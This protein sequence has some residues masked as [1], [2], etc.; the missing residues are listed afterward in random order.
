MT[1]AQMQAIGQKLLTQLW[2]ADG[3][4]VQVS[5]HTNPDPSALV[6][7]ARQ[8]GDTGRS[9]RAGTVYVSAQALNDAGEGAALEGLDYLLTRVRME[10][11]PACPMTLKAPVLAVRDSEGMRVMRE[12]DSLPF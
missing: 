3:F 8:R 6:F 4:A 2:Q 10:T 9:A 5:S 7:M 1:D 12:G 11:L